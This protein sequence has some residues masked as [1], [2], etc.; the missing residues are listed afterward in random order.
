MHKKLLLLFAVFSLSVSCPAL[1]YIEVSGTISTNTTW[2]YG[3]VYVVTGDVT[4]NSG[5]QLTI[6]PGTIVKFDTDKSLIV[7]GEF[8]SYGNASSKS[9]F[10]SFKDDSDHGLTAGGSGTLTLNNSTFTDNGD[11]ADTTDGVAYIDF[12]DGLIL[13]SSGNTSSGTGR[14]GFVVAGP[15]DESQ[16]W[17]AQIPYIIDDSG[18]TVS[19]GKILM[20]D[21]GAIV[22]FEGTSSQLSINGRLNASGSLGSP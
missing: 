21:S 10:T 6:E 15:M 20:L 7:N 16:T 8:S 1:A 9:Y 19:S 13:T 5:V 22:K 11:V 18:F 3:D 2:Q 12:S 14:K 17:T 4:V